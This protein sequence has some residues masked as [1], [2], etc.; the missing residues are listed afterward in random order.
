LHPD[1]KEQE[2]VK[3][4][5]LV[6]GLSDL[7]C[8]D[9]R[10]YGTEPLR[11]GHGCHIDVSDQSKTVLAGTN[12]KK[13]I[14]TGNFHQHVDYNL[15]TR[16]ASENKD[17]DFILIGPTEPSN[18]SAAAIRQEDLKTLKEQTNVFLLGSVPGEELHKYLNAATICLV[19]FKKEYERIHHAPHKL[20]AYFAS[21]NVILANPMEGYKT[22]PKDL[23]IQVSQEEIPTRFRELSADLAEHNSL[24]K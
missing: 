10:K 15:L 8:D 20:M 17:V 4:S 11:I 24:E 14:Y 5:D 1:S 21:G 6:I 16:L 3:T 7:I 13:A 12:T 23:M 9:L 19:L 22:V 18:I 2:L